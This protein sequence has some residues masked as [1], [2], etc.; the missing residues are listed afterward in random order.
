MLTFSLPIQ[1]KSISIEAHPVEAFIFVIALL[2]GQASIGIQF[3]ILTVRMYSEDAPGNLLV[4]LEAVRS[5]RPGLYFQIKVACTFTKV[6]LSHKGGPVYCE[7][8]LRQSVVLQKLPAD[9]QQAQS[10]QLLQSRYKEA[11]L[12]LKLGGV[13]ASW[14]VVHWYANNAMGRIAL[15]QYAE[16]KQTLEKN[17][18]DLSKWIDHK[19]ISVN[20]ST[21]AMQF[22]TLIEDEFEQHGAIQKVKAD[23]S[24]PEKFFLYTSDGTKLGHAKGKYNFVAVGDTVRVGNI[25]HFWLSSRGKRVDFAGTVTFFHQKAD[26]KL[27]LTDKKGCVKEWSNDSGHFKPHPGLMYQ[28]PFPINRFRATHLPLM[29]AARK[30]EEEAERKRLVQVTLSKLD[31]AIDAAYT[32]RGNTISAHAALDTIAN[33]TGDSKNSIKKTLLSKGLISDLKYMK[34]LPESSSSSG[35]SV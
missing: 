19:N 13:E 10:V 2:R 25:G 9:V 22:D 30:E 3:K 18:S 28:T 35:S 29:L 8:L 15:P 11:F 14:G 32:S 5:K 7:V 23:P 4:E 16:L 34:W 1:Q 33:A 27:G 31:L 20:M 6:D 17:R 21:G 26:G 24:D 12:Q